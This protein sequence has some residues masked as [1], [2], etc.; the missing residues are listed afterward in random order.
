M[1]K[2]FFRC[3]ALAWC[4]ALLMAGAGARVQAQQS[5]PPPS[6]LEQ[7][8]LSALDAPIDLEFR[9]TPLSEA[10]HSLKRRLGI[11]IRLDGNRLAAEGLSSEVPITVTIRDV[12]LA[13][14]LDLIL[15][16]LDLTCVLHDEALLI[17]SETAAEDMVTTRVYPVGDLLSSNKVTSHFPWRDDYQSLIELITGSYI[18]SG[19][20]DSE[21]G[22]SIQEVRSAKALV[23]ST[24]FHAHRDIEK[25]LANVRA[26]K[27]EQAV[28]KPQPEAEEEAVPD[29]ET[30][31][32][33][34]YR[35]PFQWP[36]NSWT[37]GGLVG[38]SG[39]A[40]MEPAPDRPAET[41]EGQ[42]SPAAPKEDQP[43]VAG[44]MRRL[45]PASNS[46]PAEDLA[47]AIPVVVEPDSWGVEG[48]SIH[49]LDYMLLVR[50]KRRVHRQI[51]CLLRNLRNRNR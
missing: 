22:Y 36:A 39:P 45:A 42:K 30:F 2:S 49:A 28:A 17:T 37:M 44:D 19:W 11:P 7:K 9:D 3:V 12:T 16:Q 48:G 43:Q 15:G 35:L 4:W 50:Q 8:L 1:L 25:L 21:S 31:Y 20:S 34:I 46:S 29:D 14:A 10:V 32:L 5:L 18:S 38:G 27:Q 41:P 23:I 33:K 6:D 24:S 13:S 40:N 26:A 51:E 47:K